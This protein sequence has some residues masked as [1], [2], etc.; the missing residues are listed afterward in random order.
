[1]IFSEDQRIVLTL[2]A[3]ETNVVFSAIQ[4]NRVIVEPLSLLAEVHKLDKSL[5]TIACGFRMVINQ[6]DEKAVAISFAFPMAAD[7][8]NGIIDNV[9][10]LPAFAGG[11]PLGPWLEKEF[12]IPVFINNDGDL[13]VY[14]EAIADQQP[15]A[16][17]YAGSEFDRVVQKAYSLEDDG[18]T[19]EFLKGETR[20]IPMPGCDE[21]MAYDPLKRIGIGLSS[22]GTSKAVGIGAYA[23]A[24]NEIDRNLK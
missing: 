20:Q 22:L 16:N 15:K 9:G 23:F 6:L 13:F 14:G 21:T 24:L 18:Q 12:G 7:Y 19:A 11:V 8:P 5:D 3:G 4:A 2:A 1:M 10:N 17:K